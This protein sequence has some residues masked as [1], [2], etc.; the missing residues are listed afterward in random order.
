MDIPHTNNGNHKVTKTV[1]A[2]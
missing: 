1:S 2:L